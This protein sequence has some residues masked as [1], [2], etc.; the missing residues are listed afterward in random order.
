LSMIKRKV[1]QGKDS[2]EKPMIGRFALHAHSIEFT[3][4]QGE[5]VCITA[6]YANDFEVFVKLLDKYDTES[7]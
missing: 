3:N 7:A 2:E 5:P 6:P 4:M 1:H